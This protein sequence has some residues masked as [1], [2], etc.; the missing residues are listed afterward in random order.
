MVHNSEEILYLAVSLVDHYLVNLLRHKETSPETVTLAVK[1]LLL[2]A[3]IEER[4]NFSKVDR[5]TMLKHF[6]DRRV[7][8]T[9]HGNN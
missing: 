5:S 4:S 2:A 8:L 9:S 7:S 1:S 6:K 3:K